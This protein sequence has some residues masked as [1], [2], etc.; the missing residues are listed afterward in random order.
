MALFRDG[1]EVSISELRNTFAKRL[2]GVEE[3]MYVDAVQQ[4]WFRVRPDK[5][6]DTWRGRGILCCCWG[7]P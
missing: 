2:E 5:I 1:S 4:G 6:R 7:S 3:S